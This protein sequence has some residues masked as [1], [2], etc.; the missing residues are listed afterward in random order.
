MRARRHDHA[1]RRKKLPPR[2]G[3]AASGGRV[4]A[5]PVV[6][7]T[8]V[9]LR[10]CAETGLANVTVPARDKARYKQ[11]KKISWGDRWAP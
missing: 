6:N 5:P 1:T 9:A 7:K 10:L 8:G 4:L 11:A 3:E 2:D